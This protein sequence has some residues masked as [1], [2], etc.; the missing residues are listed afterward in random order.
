ME[1]HRFF[2]S[3]SDISGDIAT[4]KGDEAYHLC[5]VL[6]L[7]VGFKIIVACGDEFDYH[8]TLLTV[9]EKTATAKIDS[10]I[11]NAGNPDIILHLYQSITK[12]D[13]LDLIVQKA[14]ELGVTSVT[15]FRS[16]NSHINNVNTERL[17]KIV[18]EA[19]KQCGLSKLPVLDPIIDITQINT[20]VPTICAFE[21]E[22]K[23][24]INKVLPI[25]TKELNIIV[26]PEGGFT[27]K[28]IAELKSKGVKTVSLGRR[29][30]RAETASIVM[31]ALTMSYTGG[32]TI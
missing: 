1:L 14:V 3:S 7:K 28:E 13:K 12:H 32:M 5:R 24:Q 19:A 9:N 6:R 2:I 15:L 21:W 20:S 10:K 30:L 25:K 8:C 29:I 16:A 4:I 23:V 17:N 18:R 27:D 11:L 26:G 22:D 31:I